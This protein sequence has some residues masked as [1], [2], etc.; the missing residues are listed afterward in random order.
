MVSFASGGA[1][2]NWSRSSMLGDLGMTR[3]LI[4]DDHDVVRKGL[5]HMLED[6]PR[7][8]VVAEAA[9]GQDAIAKALASKPDVAIL[10]YSMP[11][12]NGIEAA[13]QIRQRVPTVEVLL[14]TMH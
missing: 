10:D 14:F 9:D 13:R 7:W 6:Q 2:G 11:L 12:I 8:S 1:L 5:R 4:A 3:I